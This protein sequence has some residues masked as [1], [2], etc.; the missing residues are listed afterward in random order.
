MHSVQ[1]EVK[2]GNLIMK[3]LKFKKTSLSIMALF[4][5]VNLAQADFILDFVYD[6]VADA[7]VVS[8]S[9]S[10]GVEAD[11]DIGGAADYVALGDF[12]F[13]VL[14]GSPHGVN[15]TGAGPSGPYPWA[16]DVF[17]TTAEGDSFGFASSTL[18]IWGPKN[19]TPGSEISGSMTFEGKNL[20]DLGFSADEISSGGTLSGTGGDVVW[21]AGTVPEP[22]TFGLLFFGMISCVCFRSIFSYRY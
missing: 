11:A 1:S 18:Q 15:T 16:G 14:T 7:T 20:A 21:S 5:F 19:F 8:Y 13:F 2:I 12:G 4:G 22:A 6:S 17:A 10:W 3:M 9:G